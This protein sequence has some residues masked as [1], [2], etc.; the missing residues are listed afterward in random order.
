VV[1]IDHIKGL[2][3]FDLVLSTRLDANIAPLTSKILADLAIQS[4]REIGDGRDGITYLIDAQRSGI[5][6]PLTLAHE[7]KIL[8]KTGATDL[9]AALTAIRTS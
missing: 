6:T 4:A 5:I 9:A 3:G 8:D 2:A 1:R 7:A